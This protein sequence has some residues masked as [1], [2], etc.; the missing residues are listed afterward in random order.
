[1]IA[2]IIAFF[3]KVLQMQ[4]SLLHE[5]KLTPRQVFIHMSMYVV[6]PEPPSE[7]LL[8]DT[9]VASNISTFST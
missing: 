8:G 7:Y 1:M 2:V 3:A 6:I 4:F 5:A 9:E